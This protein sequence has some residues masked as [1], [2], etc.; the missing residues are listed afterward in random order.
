MAKYAFPEY[1]L[2]VEAEDESKARK[3]AEADVVAN[4]GKIVETEVNEVKLSPKEAT[5]AKLQE[6]NPET[7]LTMDNTTKEIQ[8]EIDGIEQ[9]IKDSEAKQALFATLKELNPETELTELS[10]MEDYQAEID[11]INE[12][13]TND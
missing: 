12:Q 1:S 2:T 11:L 3:I 6:L 7:E 10:S 9:L 5:F 13:K 8:A 4:G